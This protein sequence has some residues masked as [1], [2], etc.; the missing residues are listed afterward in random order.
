MD[1]EYIEKIEDKMRNLRNKR[2]LEILNQ[3]LNNIDLDNK[4]KLPDSKVLD[5]KYLGTIKIDGKLEEIYLLLEQMEKEDGTIIEIERYYNGN[6]DFLGGNNKSDQYN[7]IMLNEEYADE[8][9]LAEKIENLNKEGILDLNE[10]EE[11]KIEKI[12]NVLEIEP[13]DIQ[14][15]AKLKTKEPEENIDKK[16]L[17]KISSKSEIKANQKVTDKETIA[18]ILNV[19]GQGFVDFNIVN[20]EKLKDNNNT[21][22]FTI[23]GEKKNGKIEKID[24]LEQ[25]YGN[26]PTKEIQQLNRDGSEMKQNE[27][28]NSIFR[29]K[30]RKESQIAIDIGPM[31][32]IETALVR[33]PE[34][35][36]QEAIS[37]PIETANIRP[38][39]TEIREFINEK[40]NPRIKEEIQRIKEHQKVDCKEIELRDIDDNQYNNTHNHIEISKEYLEK[41]AKKIL[42]ND[43]ISSVY[44]SKD[45]IKKLKQFIENTEGK[46]TNLDTNELLEKVENEMQQ[47]AQLEHEMR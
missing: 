35:D 45:V 39:T 29:I 15:V 1:K 36:N 47:N 3:L 23:V 30:G 22:P 28:V 20:S 12:A 38:T 2:D 40:R 32:T 18:E 13:K 31:G 9:K 26:N 19:E 14:R 25:A 46:E 10:L 5:V 17:E 11:E 41:C 37:V 24:T 8:A 33:T 42:E 7:K 27:Q 4:E 6:G 43:K 16:E 44:N 34:Q 21:T